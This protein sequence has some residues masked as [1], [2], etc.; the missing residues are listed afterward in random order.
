MNDLISRSAL[1]E[2]LSKGTIVTD[3]LY[4]M[5]IMAGNDHAMKKIEAAPAVDAVEVVRCKDCKH[6]Y[7]GSPHG[8]MCECPVGGQNTSLLGGDDFCSNGERRVD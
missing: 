8:L 4:G 5:G 2:E 1:L 3:D 7:K 6:S